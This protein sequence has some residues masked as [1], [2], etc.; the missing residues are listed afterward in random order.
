MRR[1]RIT[2]GPVTAC[3]TLTESRTAAAIWNALPLSARAHRWGEEIYFAIPVALAP[4]QPQAVVAAGDLG[5]WPPGR[6]FCIFW[7]PTPASRGDE[8]RPA[9]PVNV[10][11][12]IEGDA[13]LFATVPDGTPVRV[14]RLEENGPPAPC[15]P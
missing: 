6:A 15:P 1:V 4:E 5:Y 9:S 11:G 3:A 2:A 10:F 8:I 14:V 13:T 12:C 7:G